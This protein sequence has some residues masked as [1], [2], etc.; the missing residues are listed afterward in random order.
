MKKLLS[1]IL[2][3]FLNLTLLAN[4]N[5]C[6]TP[7]SDNDVELE[8]KKIKAH[9]FEEAKKEILEKFLVGNCFTSDQIRIILVNLSFEEHKLELAKKAYDH[10]TDKENYGIIS[11]VFEFDDAKNELIEFIKKN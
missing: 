4:S 11:S 10:V 5:D 9:D 8:I 6:S 2:L 3:S 7:I 1:L